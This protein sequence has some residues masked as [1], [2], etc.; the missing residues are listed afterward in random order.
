MKLTIERLGHHG[1]GIA[2]GPVFVPRSL[3]G[4]VVEGEV[5]NGRVAQPSVV[6]PSPDRVRPPCP[7][8]RSCGGC[9]L[10]HG[11]DTFV[12]GWKAVSVS[13]A[14]RSQGLN[15]AI[16]GV[17]TSPAQSRR[18]AV[19]SGRRTKKGALVGFHAR[20]SDTIIAIPDCTLLRPEL[21][22]AVPMLEEMVANGATRK[23][24]LSL[25]VTLSD[26]G[27]DIAVSGGKDM[28]RDLFSLLAGLSEQH[29]LARLSWNSDVVVTRRP[30]YQ[31]FGAA[32]V[33]PPPGAFLQAT[34]H[35]QLVL[36][37]AVVNAAHGATRIVD[38]FAGCGT[39]SLPLA[40]MAEVH[41]VEGSVEMTEA[42]VQGWRQAQGLKSVSVEAR[43][44]FRR[45]LLPDELARFD[46]AVLD[47][48]RAGAE[49][50][51]E[52]I[53]RS[54]LQKLVMVSCNPQSFARDARLLSDAGFTPGPVTVVD[55]FRW[56]PHIELVCSFLR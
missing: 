19:L 17:A 47:P 27:L 5:E 24:E 13:A 56:S 51:V 23:G 55:Q 12:S 16:V 29:D 8:F 15:V 44:L 35:G 10:Q 39:F 48:P 7:H 42:L 26:A 41:A 28:D 54:E 18:R 2:P 38:L 4:E 50:Q 14:L 40:Q 37:D 6:T 30:P 32:Q 31:N 20:A 22:A 3:P 11:S 53:A 25:N 21:I 52:Q 46:M 9:A 49:A 45:P 34:A 33:V 36:T 43:D 1:D